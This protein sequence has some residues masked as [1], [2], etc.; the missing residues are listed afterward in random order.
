MLVFPGGPG[1]PLWDTYHELVRADTRYMPGKPATAGGDLQAP[2]ADQHPG[3]P[4]S[5][6]ERTP[7][8]EASG[9]KEANRRLRQELGDKAAGAVAE[10]Q[11][12]VAQLTLQ[13]RAL[14]REQLNVLDRLA[15]SDA[16]RALDLKALRVLEEQLAAESHWRTAAEHT[17]ADINLAQPGT[18]GARLNEKLVEIDNRVYDGVERLLGASLY[19][20]VR[21]LLFGILPA[22][23]RPRLHV[24]HA[25]A[26]DGQAARVVRRDQ[27]GTLER[28][29]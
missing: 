8:G 14:A 4:G 24:L 25:G 26:S 10:L 2:L 18:V 15:K 13:H 6:K 11:A 16:A 23:K 19:E 3:E 5:K 21:F 22:A 9:R 17:L 7:M 12:S 1:T 28:L 27:G 29:S 20:R